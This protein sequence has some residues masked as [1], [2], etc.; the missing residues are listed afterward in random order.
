MSSHISPLCLNKYSW[1]ISMQRPLPFK[2]VLSLYLFVTGLLPHFIFPNFLI[3]HNL[4]RSFA[5]CGPNCI[6]ILLF[7]RRDKSRI[8][9][10]LNMWQ[11]YEVENSVLRI[12]RRTMLM[13][14][15][16]A[17]LICYYLSN[18]VC[19]KCVVAAIIKWQERHC[20][21]KFFRFSFL[22][23]KIVMIWSKILSFFKILLNIIY[24]RI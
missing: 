20:I 21:W 1:T 22:D 3:H 9:L 4:S 12:Y 7:N 11:L 16:R 17:K 19:W 13:P 15:R 23:I 6:C 18:K 8:C 2:S 10:G 14:L 24:S 5:E